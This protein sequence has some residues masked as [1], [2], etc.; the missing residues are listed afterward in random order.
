MLKSI[1]E[2]L[3][4]G[5]GAAIAASGLAQASGF[6]DPESIAWK[7]RYG[8]SS[9]TYSSVWQ[10]YKN[11]GYL[12]I[13]IETDNA[14][15]VKYSGVWQK[16][17]DGRSWA[18]WRNLT[19]R[20]FSARWK[21]YSD[22][23]YRPIDQ[24]TEVVGGQVQY[25]LV[26]VQNK[27]GLKWK[28]S[29]N[30][31]S[32]QF[33][34]NFKANK[35]TYKPIDIDAVEIRGQMRYSII[36]LEN[37]EKQGWVELRDMSPAYYGKK[38]NQYRN[39]GY[40]VADIDC[41]RRE[42][43]LTYAAIWEKN[44]PGRGWAALRQMSA[45]SLR[46]AW[47]KYND[48]GLR[49]VDIEICPAST[50]GG[51]QYAA[52][53]REN[54]SR[55]DWWGRTDAKKALEDFVSDNDAPGVAAAIIHK[56][57]VVFRGGSGFANAEKKIAAHSGTI[58][59]TASVSKA[60]TG[61]LGFDMQDDMIINLS[62]LT[63]TIVTSLE[64]NH[65]H[66]ILEL[67]QNTSCVG[68]Y[69]DVPGDE[70]NDQMQ[71]A[72]AQAVLSDKQDGV[73]S[74]NDAIWTP[75]TPGSNYKYSTHG[76]TIAAAAYEIKGR[77]TFDV[78]LRQRISDK[79]GLSTLRAETRSSP[80]SIGELAKLY[81]KK[82]GGGYKPVTDSEFENT[83][84]KWGGGGLEASPLDLAKFGNALLDNALFPKSVRDQMWSGSGANS[85]YGAGWNLNLASN[86]TLVENRGSQQAA[87]A[88]IRIDVDDDI[89]VVAMT[90]V[91]YAI[92]KER[93]I[94]NILTS[95]LMALAKA[96]P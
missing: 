19:S 27:E 16:N 20:E 63:D 52:V 9:S 46:N 24:D 49:I 21:R 95:S 26:M 84:W 35:G 75:C 41:Y 87:L 80:N 82:S 13:D 48:E 56:G 79:L 55:Y 37:K 18:S 66:T 45:M 36:W 72:S 53:W 15:G 33:S 81:N 89:V 3:A 71:Y 40:R 1:K 96:Y 31:T 88:N 28:S 23:G 67:L 76:Y 57:K 58:Y 69:K 54:E 70:N 14:S 74:S 90:N 77:K 25:S 85:R 60:I 61:A 94:I 44:Q 62:D 17:T 42:G 22:K 68:N 6:D 2:V 86:P 78:L 92:P 73:L 7:F 43:H 39:Q 64:T 32:I 5:I 93:R 59:R 38:F 51:V 50:G 10:S 34:E 83:S 11:S 65:R 29:R 4:F 8:L 12:P 47:K 91:H 30:L